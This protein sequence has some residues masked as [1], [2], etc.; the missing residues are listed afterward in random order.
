MSTRGT[1]T[2]VK[3]NEV[4]AQT[5]DKLISRDFAE[6]K[7][8]PKNL[9]SYAQSAME[10]VETPSDPFV[11]VED[12][13]D[14]P[15]FKV[16]NRLP[17]MGEI[18]TRSTVWDYYR[19][20][21]AL[22]NPCDIL[23]Q[24]GKNIEEFDQLLVDARVKT[25]LNNRRAGCLSRQ[26][27]VEQNKSPQRF[28]NL[29][30][31]IF[32]TFPIYD[33]MGEMLLGSF[34]GYYLSEVIWEEVDNKILPT[35]IVGKHPRWFVYSDLNMLRYKTKINQVAGETLPPRKFIASRYHPSY[36]DPYAGRENLAAA[37]YWPVKFRHLLIQYA[38]S[39]TE[40]YGTPFIDVTVDAT[41]QVK[42]RI[43][44]A[45]DIIQKTFQD[46]IIGHT[47]TTKIS[48]I[49]KMA[50]SQSTENYSRMID[51]FNREIDMAILGCNLVTEVTGG[52][53]AASKTHA[54]IRQDI[55]DEDVRMIEASFNQLIEWIAYY[56]F[57]ANVEMP[58]FKLYKDEPAD[59]QQSI[60]DLNLTKMGVKFKPE[61]YVRKYLLEEDEFEIGSQLLQ[62]PTAPGEPA[63][64]IGAD[65]KPVA[66]KPKLGGG[67]AEAVQKHGIETK[68]QASNTQTQEAVSRAQ[69]KGYSYS[70][71]DVKKNR[72][73]RWHDF[74]EGVKRNEAPIRDVVNSHLENLRDVVVSTRRNFDVQTA[75]DALES[76]IA[77]A[78]TKVVST[79][80]QFRID[81]M[82]T[83]IGNLKAFKFDGNSDN[84]NAFIY[85]TEDYEGRMKNILES[86]DTTF[87][88]F[89]TIL[90][91]PDA[92]DFAQRLGYS[93]DNQEDLI[94]QTEAI[95]A[96]NFGE[97]EAIM[98]AD[99]PEPGVLK[100]WVTE[101][102]D[103]VRE[104]H[105]AAQ[106][107]YYD[108]IPID[109]EFVVGGDSM[110]YPGEGDDPEQNCNCRCTCDYIYPDE[111]SVDEEEPD[112][113]VEGD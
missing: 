17:Y 109:E 110:Q 26:W 43:A 21:V 112:V 103:K 92:D 88:R 84:V 14:D 54:G 75:K 100:T 15:R 10:G 74:I 86:V 57:P 45:V 91:D 39:F 67:D 98:Q 83:N 52:S 90:K 13:T 31:R 66:P 82:V 2:L 28:F 27:M 23:T 53:Y 11:G 6:P 8:P 73:R 94:V 95:A 34:Y 111:V 41:G 48:A 97:V 101:M 30:D 40:K 38:M 60:I 20:T 5:I 105:A 4:L 108:G 68:D 18:V 44:E 7:D 32:H 63:P 76:N 16:E 25:C 22:P 85:G 35:S 65:G 49:E 99:L 47:E 51:L 78:L 80:G 55:I 9:P 104:D 79:S 71:T 59:Q 19:T 69:S 42:E 36:A 58:K 24:L 50:N 72:E 61:Y 37:V 70:E 102:D 46:G 77:P 89:A 29:V 64:K 113:E 87:D 1:R 106:D 33:I 56:N 62:A 12:T 93:I 107:E 96:S 3:T 81:D